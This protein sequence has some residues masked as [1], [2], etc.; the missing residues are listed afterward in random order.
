MSAMQSFCAD[1]GIICTMNE[2]NGQKTADLE[3]KHLS[4]SNRMPSKT[5]RICKSEL[6]CLFAIFPV[7]VCCDIC[8]CIRWTLRPQFK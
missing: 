6:E 8:I 7:T 4:H 2:K 5:E 3:Y 1:I